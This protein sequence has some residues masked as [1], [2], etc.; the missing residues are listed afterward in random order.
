MRSVSSPYIYANSHFVPFI[1]EDD[2]E[3]EE[4]VKGDDEDNYTYNKALFL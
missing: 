4:G 3:E 2:E 1:M